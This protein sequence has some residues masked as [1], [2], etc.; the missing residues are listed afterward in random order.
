V[1]GD[2]IQLV[3]LNQ[4]GAGRVL[5]DRAG[6]GAGGAGAGYGREIGLEILILRKYCRLIIRKG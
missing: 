6:D 5:C 2:S 3:G 1:L 4:A